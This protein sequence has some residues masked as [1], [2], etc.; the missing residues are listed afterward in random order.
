MSIAYRT[1]KR[2]TD[3]LMSALGLVAAAPVIAVAALAVKLDSRGPVFFGHERVGKWGRPFKVWKIRTMREDSES[4]GAAVTAA[5]DPRVTRV[6]RRLRAFK[7]DELPQFWNVLKGEMSL[8]GPRPEV[9][10]YVNLFESQY[11]K[12]LTVRPGITDEAS[13]QYRHEEDLL[14]T[15]EDPEKTYIEQVLPRKIERYLAYIDQP[16]LRK[17]FSILIRTLASILR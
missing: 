11:G 13:L 7:I 16:S 1:A 17:D 14:A 9:A 6:G 8:V 15:C 10:R 12:I 2:T 3:I 4:M 5:G